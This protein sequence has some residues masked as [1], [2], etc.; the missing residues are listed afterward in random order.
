MYYRSFQFSP[1]GS[2]VLYNADQDTDEVYEIYSCVVSQT[3]HVASGQWDRS[4]NWDQGEVPDEVMSINVNP[5]SFE[6]VTSPLT[7]T[8]IFFLNIG[9]TDTGVAT[10]ALQPSV[11]L[12]VLN[13][14]EISNRGA[15]AGSGHFD[16]QGGLVNDGRVELDGMTIAA[17]TI[18]NNGVI[19][20]SG[21]IGAQLMNSANGEVRVAAGQQIHLADTGS[22]SN[23]GRI[24]VVGNAT[25][26]AEIEF[27]GAVTNASSTGVVVGENATFRF[28]GGLT[29][30]GATALSFGTSRVFG[31][32]NNA[33]GTIIVSG[34]SNI[35]FYDDL[36]NN[37]I[38]QVSKGSTAVYFG[39]VS[40]S[41]SL[42]GSGTNFFEG[43]LAPGSSPGTMSFGGDVVLG[44]ASTTQIELGG[45]VAGEYD[46]LD[47]TGS[48]SLASTLDTML[49]DGFFPGL[50]DTFTI[51]SADG[52]VTGTFDTTNMPVLSGGL[53]LDLVY[54]PTFVALKVISNLLLGDANND[55]QV[56]GADLVIVQQNFGNVDPNTPTD[57]LF[58]GDANDDGKVTGADLIIVQQNFGNTLA[59]VG[60]EVPEPAWA[61]LLALAGLGAMARRRRVAS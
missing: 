9:A 30:E 47:I 36:V 51:I 15:L 3:W 61:C 26:T 33:K 13:Q 27:D 44:T 56:T 54:R 7:D 37:K 32:I 8:S 24:D 1:D 48:V 50:G 58:I 4:A 11:T 31:D 18:E 16:S 25:Q 2:R 14:T 29:N 53:S 41:G 12:T 39:F 57:G 20:G 23:A 52:G 22:Q 10:L 6:T 21:T 35:T 60:A 42:T 45:T 19:S 43:D 40:G 5:V 49:I 38:V 55:N 34:S 17:P 28:N 59:P 46:Q